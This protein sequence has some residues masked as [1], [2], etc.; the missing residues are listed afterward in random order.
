MKL[1]SYIVVHDSGFAPNPF[2][3]Y[4]TLACCKPSIRRSARRGDWVLGLSQ[5]NKGNKVIFAMEVTEDSLT[6]ARYH[7]DRRFEDKIPAMSRTEI[8]H[9]CGDNIY[10]PT[11]SGYKQLP[12]PYHSE[13]EKDHD[14]G[15]RN[16]LV[17]DHFYYLGSESVP[18][19]D[20]LTELIAGRGHKCNFPPELIHGFFEFISQLKPGV[21]AAPTK[22]PAYD[23]SWKCF[24]S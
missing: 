4:C 1:Y 18:L 2:W 6:F 12:N 22:W 14:L 23:D 10:Q 16:V 3:G 21:N 8:V 9:R 20:D 7:N 13:Q 11:P 17:S 24:K 15:G 5:R 19:P